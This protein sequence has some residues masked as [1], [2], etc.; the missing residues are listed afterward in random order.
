MYE[1]EIRRV[2]GLS[3]W[4]DWLDLTT[5]CLYGMSGEDFERAYMSGSIEKSGTA[6]DI[7]S[8]LPLI[9]RLRALPQERATQHPL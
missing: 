7:A 2:F 3:D 1:I 5:R 4:T 6:S 9:R 8:I